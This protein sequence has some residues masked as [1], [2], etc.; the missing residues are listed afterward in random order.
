MFNKFFFFPKIMAVL[1]NAE[2]KMTD[3][4]MPQ[5]TKRRIPHVLLHT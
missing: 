5:M 1:Y 3:P 2:K 4:D